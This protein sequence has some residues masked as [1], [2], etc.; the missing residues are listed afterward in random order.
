MDIS[1]ESIVRRKRLPSASSVKG[2][3]RTKQMRFSFSSAALEYR[4]GKVSKNSHM[5]ILQ[6]HF[7]EDLIKN[8]LQMRSDFILPCIYI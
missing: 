3:P 2:F 1:P 4:E 7:Y 8:L 5:V 6:I